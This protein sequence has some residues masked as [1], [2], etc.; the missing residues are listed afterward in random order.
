MGNLGRAHRCCRCALICS[1]AGE[2]EVDGIDGVR[3]RVKKTVICEAE[4]Q[5]FAGLRMKSTSSTRPKIAP[6]GW[7]PSNN[8]SP[9]SGIGPEH[10]I[11]Q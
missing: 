9:A 2:H 3:S 10:R 4:G 7:Q 5:S 11:H 6:K 1:R 8:S